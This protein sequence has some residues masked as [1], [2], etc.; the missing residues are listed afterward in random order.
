MMLVEIDPLPCGRTQDIV[1]A[2]CVAFFRDRAGEHYV[3]V[4]WYEKAGTR[5]VD[6]KARLVKVKPMA[7]NRVDSYDI[8]P[9]GSI[10][11]GAL[12]VQDRGMKNRPGA[13]PHYWVRQSPREYNFLL[14]FYGIRPFV[15]GE[16]QLRRDR[17]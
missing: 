3:A 11:N 2:R 15:D 13:Q 14:D 7:V 10:L 12:L 1:F 4:H 9:V 6:T 17:L 8:M 5:Q 16:S